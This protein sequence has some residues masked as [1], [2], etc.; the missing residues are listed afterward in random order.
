MQRYVP[1]KG[2]Y[3]D[4]YWSLWGMASLLPMLAFGIDR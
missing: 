1:H 2:R 3:L 4:G